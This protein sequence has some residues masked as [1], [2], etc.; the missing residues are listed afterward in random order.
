M[1]KANDDLKREIWNSIGPQQYVYLATADGEQPRVRP[2]TLIHFQEKLYFI[3]GSRD[4]KMIQ[5]KKNPKVEFCLLLEK[6]DHKG[7]LRGECIAQIVEEK[8]LKADIF[9]EISFVKE[10]FASPEDPGY[11]LVRLKPLGFEIMKPGEMQAEKIT[12]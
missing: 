1:N 11:A 2:V 3:T 8:K 5:I 12:L 4:S 7:T 10:F 9:D 6:D